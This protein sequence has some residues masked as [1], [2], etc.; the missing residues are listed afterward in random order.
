MSQLQCRF[1][2]A[3][4]DDLIP[5]WL[6]TERGRIAN[7]FAAASDNQIELD[8]SNV[9]SFSPDNV[10][11]N[12]LQL[13][14]TLQQMLGNSN[15][16]R[17]VSVIGV[18][19]A[20]SFAPRPETFGLMFDPGDGFTG[21]PDTDGIAREGCAVFLDAIRSARQGTPSQESGTFS[22]PVEAET[23]FTT[24][25]ELGHVFNLWHSEG[26]INYMRSS[27]KEKTAPLSDEGFVGDQRTFLAGD[28]YVVLPGGA[29]FGERR[30]MGPTDDNPENAPSRWRQ[31]KLSL[32]MSD[33]EFFFFQPVELEVTVGTSSQ[34][35]GVE[36]PDVI[37]PGY[38]SFDIFIEEPD[39]Q[40]RTLRSPRRYCPD[41]K[42]R[43]IKHRAPF[44]RDISVFGDADGFVFRQSGPHRIWARLRF[45]KQR[46]LVSNIVDVNVLQ[47]ADAP[48]DFSRSAPILS[49]PEVASFLYHR[50]APGRSHVAD[51]VESGA[52]HIRRV[53]SKLAKELHYALGRFYAARAS[54]QN[55]RKRRAKL[56]LAA[57]KH[58][59]KALTG[60]ELSRH[61]RRVAEN[62]LDKRLRKVPSE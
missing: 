58:L 14:N 23:F 10:G 50:Y 26:A 43:T 33:Y 54:R 15:K 56:N 16:V 36:I 27:A 22:D 13:Q 39:G 41:G 45:S 2:L 11:V 19:Y 47:H 31:L 48:R 3:A 12:A 8:T 42:V 18:V 55:T 4:S 30:G 6:S 24:V 35:D 32:R 38:D 52:S 37:D 5:N 51:L 62:I 44:R 49:R 34:A 46:S 29:R 21:L 59:D 7:L 1:G 17:Q 53:N 9:S 60:N 28:P 25:H 40:R 20:H 57:T 61:R